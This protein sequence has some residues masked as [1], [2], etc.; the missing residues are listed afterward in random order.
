MPNFNL[1]SDAKNNS[2]IEIPQNNSINNAL[3]G[4][5]TLGRREALQ[6]LL[7]QNE[8]LDPNIRTDS[9]S[10]PVLIAAY[11]N[12][13]KILKLLIDHGA[14]IKDV[15]DIQGKTVMVFAQR[16]ENKKM[17]TLINETLLKEEMEENSRLTY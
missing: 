17:I 15:K 11:R 12:D 14:R 8:D 7:D 2:S 3:I 9:G 5:V 16:Y 6:Q 13:T 10:S 4:L 1:S